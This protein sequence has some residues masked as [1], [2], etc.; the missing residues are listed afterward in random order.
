[1][2]TTAATTVR[3]R[4]IF[5]SGISAG[6]AAFLLIA[7]ALIRQRLG[8]TVF[9]AFNWALSLATIGEALMDFGIHQV[10][11]RTIAA[12][13]STARRIFQNSL[14][15]KVVPALLMVVALG[16]VAYAYQSE[17]DIRTTCWLMLLGAVLRSYLMTIRGLLL[18]LERFSD[19]TIVVVGDRVLLLG[20]VIVALA[21]GGGL[22]SLGVAFVAARVVSVAGGLWL[23][24]R[25]VGA[26]RPAFDYDLWREIQRHALPLGAF[27]IVLNVYNYVDTLLL[28]IMRN[29]GE[30]GIYSQAY[31]LYE[32]IT[33]VP[34]I[35]ASVL[36]PRLS[37]L[38]GTD[39]GAHGALLRRGLAAS[40]GLAIVCTAAFW[41]LAPLALTVVFDAADP[42]SVDT[43]RVL[44]LGLV[45]VFA[46]WIL[47][48]AAISG[49]AQKLLL[50]TT[51]VGVVANTGLNLWLIP[52]YGSVG[53]AW[54]TIAGEALTFGILLVGLRGM[55]TGGDA[56]GRARTSPPSR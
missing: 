44:A 41:W 47:H 39:P 2:T 55:L 42:A 36:T 16:A 18:G 8:V 27:L 5:F 1:M 52:A 22:T 48:A 7:I 43:L 4:N 56:R 12:D 6:S 51:A 26:P 20:A 10:T 14:A 28:G 30:V 50:G 29:N 17:A 31:K 37:H 46:I 45:F 35:L 21:D 23:T 13:R 54:A 3:P 38:W 33:Y 11:I 15:L 49:F 34:A 40:V 19:E 24:Y 25:Q 9:G 32:G 53:A